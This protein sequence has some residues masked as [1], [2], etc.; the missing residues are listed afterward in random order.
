MEYDSKTLSELKNICKINKYKNYSNKNKKDLIEFLKNK[1][2]NKTEEKSKTGEKIFI[3]KP[4]LKWLGGKT[5]IIDKIIETFPKSL[6]N[7]HEIF[8]GGGSVLFA[9]LSLQKANQI[10]I[11][12]KIYAYDINSSLIN[13][14]KNIQNNKNELF[15]YIT[16]Y[17]SI[18][19]KLT[20]TIINRN[21]Q[22]EE[23]NLSSKESYYYYL[24]NKFNTMDKNSIE[25][26]ALFLFLNKICFRGVYREGPKGF[27]VPYGHY[28]T[29]PTIIS[30]KELDNI[31]DLIKNVKFIC[32]DFETSIKN[33]KSGDFTYLDP[34]YAP[35]TKTSF[36]KYTKEGFTLD[37]HKKLFNLINKCVE[38]NIKL[39][40]SNAKVDLV[41][42]SF[43]L[44]KY[45]MNDIIAKRAINSKKPESVITEII[46][47]N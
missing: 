1:S 7:Y 19:D 39:A 22:T 4:F 28:K 47:Y 24:R 36:V 8:L 17:L 9:L 10:E 13:L 45:K 25:F 6:N 41:L 42:S 3:Q 11:K 21:P 14:Y 37:K 40:M 20:G 44:K 26:S 33:I 38:N 43:D 18:Y 31:S 27:N 34:P 29:T 30:K 35:E 2:L 46:I 5:N 32:C 15:N 16:N 23:E 12:N